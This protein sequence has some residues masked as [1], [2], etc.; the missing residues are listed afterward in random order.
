M[1]LGQHH[2]SAPC[3]KEFVVGLNGD[4]GG[5]DHDSQGSSRKK[6][7]F[8]SINDVTK[9]DGQIYEAEGGDDDLWLGHEGLCGGGAKGSHHRYRAYPKE[10][11]ECILSPFADGD[12]GDIGNGLALVALGDHQLTEIMDG[13]NKNA[14]RD[15]PDDAT[16]PAEISNAY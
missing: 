12:S 5:Q 16:E 6:I 14:A 11:R 8:H 15:N 10:D 3:E 7:E 4:T 9:S 1:N 13:A 2:L